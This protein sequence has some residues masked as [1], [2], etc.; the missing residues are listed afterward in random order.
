M[1][2]TSLSG[3]A[4]R[5]AQ[6]P[7]CQEPVALLIQSVL[8][9]VRP[10]SLRKT[11][12]HATAG[13][14]GLQKAR[15]L[16]SGLPGKIAALSER[17]ARAGLV[18][19]PGIAQRPAGLRSPPVVPAVWRGPVALPQACRPFSWPLGR[20]SRTCPASCCPLRCVQGVLAL[21]FLLCDFTGD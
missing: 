21:L 13:G 15:Q 20:Q 11:C 1:C 19:K 7:H 9:R 2:R 18:L 6:C 5:T 17:R 12:L 14:A 4:L 3:R 10:E 8:G 16:C